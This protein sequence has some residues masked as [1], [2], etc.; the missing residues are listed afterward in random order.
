MAVSA[1]FV[2]RLKTILLPG[3]TTE[4]SRLMAA[5]T[6]EIKETFDVPRNKV[7]ALFADHQSFGKILGAPVKRIKDSLQADPNGI[8][9]VRKIGFGPVG[10]KESIINF[11]PDTLI[12][13]TLISA[14]PI[15][16]H[17]GRIRFSEA[18]GGQTCVHYT[19]TFNDIIPFSGK[20]VATAL[21]QAIRRGIRRIP[22]LA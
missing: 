5:Y 3:S 13:Y 9:S 16:N 15:R 8:G 14:S 11:E 21:E 12:E 6:V 1:T 10:L 22:K 19:I 7:F 2:A 20:V 4:K 18:Q 17:F